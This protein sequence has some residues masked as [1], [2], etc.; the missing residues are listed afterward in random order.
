MDFMHHNSPVERL[1]LKNFW[2]YAEADVGSVLVGAYKFM[3][4]YIVLSH[5]DARPSIIVILDDIASIKKTRLDRGRRSFA[6]KMKGGKIVRINNA[7]SWSF[8]VK[9]GM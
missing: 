5:F 1:V 4:P 7:Y 8:E 9:L 3:N 6:I 2:H